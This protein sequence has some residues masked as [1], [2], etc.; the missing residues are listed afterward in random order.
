MNLLIITFILSIIQLT[1][2][3]DAIQD[4]SIYSYHTKFGIPSATKIKEWE[5]ALNSSKSQR[6]VGGK[7]TDIAKVPYQVSNK[8]GKSYGIDIWSM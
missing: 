8:R 7:I 5:E 1:L 3:K 6:I 4:L 2:S